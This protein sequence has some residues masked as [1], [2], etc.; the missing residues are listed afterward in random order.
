[1]PLAVDPNSL[2]IEEK[3]DNYM[4]KVNLTEKL[5]LFTEHWSPRIVGELNG[6]YVK[7]AKLAGEFEWHK[8]PNE[9][10]LFLVLA[11]SLVIK[12]RDRDV[13]L[14]EGE[15]FIVNRCVEHKP[16]AEGEV[17]VLLFEPVSTINTG[18]RRSDRTVEDLKWI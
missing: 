11:G 2:S 16:V 4:E 17:H 12:L 9:D 3:R 13:R 14:E 6:Q 10:E 15:F 1:M 18:D 7:L 5:S 8:H